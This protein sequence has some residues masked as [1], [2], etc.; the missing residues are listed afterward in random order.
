MENKE[1]LKVTLN[2]PADSLLPG[3]SVDCVIFGFHN[4]TMKILLSKFVGYERWMIPGGFI[5]KDEN[6]D[7]AASR[8]LNIRTGLTNMHLKQFHT[9]GKKDRTSLEENEE[10]LLYSGYNDMEEREKHWLMQRFVSI[11]Y[12]A[13]VE[14]SKVKII[15]N[16]NEETAWIDLNE[17][18][19]LY[20]DHNEII[21][22]ALSFI[23]INLSI[24]PVGYELL[25]EKFTMT[26]L[27]I[28]YETILGKR[29]D[30][31]NFQ[32]KMLSS[33]LIYKLTEVSK[34]FGVKP[35]TLFAFDADKYQTSLQNGFLIFD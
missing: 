11:G 35:S 19:Q 17:I 34:K 5:L 3:L 24:L 31:R 15:P 18:P 7:D 27:R 23:K 13:L 4:G 21:R 33:G 22:K 26:E 6:T 10:L 9:F 16:P 14:Y 8:I 29:L 2:R 28:I 1:L 32:R 20:S 12:Y 25:P 30:R